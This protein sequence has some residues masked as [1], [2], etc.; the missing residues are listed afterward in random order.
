MKKIAS[1]GLILFL[2]LFTF[3]LCKKPLSKTEEMLQF[4]P[5]QVQGVLFAD[6]QK[7]METNIADE[8]IKES[9]LKNKYQKFIQK[10]GINPKKDLH[11]MALAVM[12]KKEQAER[13]GVA[14]FNLNY[15]R[16]KLLSL[17]QKEGPELTKNQYNGIIIYS[18]PQEKENKKQESFA[19]LDDSHIV[20]G[21]D[22]GVKSV[23]DVAEGREENVHQNEA[24]ADLLGKTNQ[25]GMLWGGMMFSPQTMEKLASDNPMLRNLKSLHSAS[26]YLDYKNK[27]LITEIKMTSSDETKIQELVDLLNG[28]K[29]LGSMAS[30]KR[31]EIGELLKKIE[32]TAQPEYAQISAHIPDELLQKFKKRALEKVE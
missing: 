2:I 6:F 30:E 20:V 19:F 13:K 7:I 10:S 21:N 26:L 22:S 23:I 29:A 28:I 32:I 12:E 1:L 31:P 24:L 4:I 25:Q 5:K 14:V 9:K 11:A 18:T 27:N 3:D 17:A 16:D 8:T 15:T